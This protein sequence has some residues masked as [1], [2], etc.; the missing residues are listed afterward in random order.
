VSAA[1]EL[2]KRLWTLFVVGRPGSPSLK[3]TAIGGV[4]FV[5]KGSAEASITVTI[6]RPT[7]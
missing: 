2:P 4:A 3:S 7:A 6:G 1:C 5:A